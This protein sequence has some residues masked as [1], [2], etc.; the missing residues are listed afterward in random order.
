MNATNIGAFISVHVNEYARKGPV[1]SKIGP[2]ES[3]AE[4]SGP[5]IFCV[6]FDR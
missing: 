5:F 1:H 4:I 3:G 2:N 6:A